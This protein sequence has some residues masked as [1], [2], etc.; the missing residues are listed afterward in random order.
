MDDATHAHG[1]WAH[2]RLE[3]VHC[4]RCVLRAVEARREVAGE[5]VG[6]G[7]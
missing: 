2:T 6:G 3:W 4:T 1:Q 5:R 7:K